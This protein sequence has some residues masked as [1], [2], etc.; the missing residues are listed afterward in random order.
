MRTPN[1]INYWL[2]LITTLCALGSISFLLGNSE[3]V[4]DA[5]ALST[6]SNQAITTIISTEQTQDIATEQEQTNSTDHSTDQ[7]PTKIPIKT[8]DDNTSINQW[9]L[10]TNTAT[11]LLQTWLFE[12]IQD[13]PQALL[14]LQQS[15][16]PSDIGPI[17]SWNTDSWFSWNDIID[18]FSLGLQN[19]LQQNPLTEYIPFAHII[20]KESETIIYDAADLYSLQEQGVIISSF[21]SGEQLPSALLLTTDLSYRTTDNQIQITLPE[22]SIIQTQN[23]EPINTHDFE[24]VKNTWATS[25]VIIQRYDEN[26]NTYIPLSEIPII[27]E[28]QQEFH[29]G[30]SWEHLIF[31]KPLEIKIYTDRGN[32]TLVD[33]MANHA[34]QWRSKDWISTDPATDCEN[35]N[36]AIPWSI[37]KVVDNSVTFYICSASVFSLTYVWWANSSNFC[38]NNN[39]TKTVQF[40]TWVHFSTWDIITDV[41]LS[42]RRRPIDNRNPAAFGTWQ[43]NPWEKYFRLIHPDGTS[44]TLI[45]S[46]QLT[47]PS[48]NC[49]EVTTIFDM[50]WTNVIT[51]NYSSWTYKPVESFT[52]FYNKSPFGTWWLLFGDTAFDRWVI[53]YKYTLTLTTTTWDASS[54]TICLYGPDSISTWFTIWWTTGVYEID[55]GYFYVGVL[56][57]S[58]PPYYTTLD[59]QPLKIGT[60]LARIYTWQLERKTTSGIVLFSWGIW[61]S[62]LSTWRTGYTSVQW[63]RVFIKSDVMPNKTGLIWAYLRIKANISPYSVVGTYNWEIVYTLYEI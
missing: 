43:C 62:Y 40:I 54:W 10:S 20:N 46:W 32:E 4:L 13:S 49:P 17:G 45:D 9:N 21:N 53:L 60:G 23:E 1:T 38:D 31:S 52:W 15:V 33:I 48:S 28:N 36:A 50:S 34:H 8:P 6:D 57:Q 41:D 14:E 42:V 27:N 59:L 19:P 35:G 61:N 7:L 24:L 26:N 55:I 2:L 16:Q 5:P 37:A 12:T 22:Q 25:M 11:Q 18:W 58:A 51:W 56:S 3:Q 63:P 39:K 44:K 30:I 29:F 47:T